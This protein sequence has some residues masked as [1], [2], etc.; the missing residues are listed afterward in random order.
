VSGHET[1]FAWF[2]GANGYF[3]FIGCKKISTFHS[4]CN[5]S[6]IQSKSFYIFSSIFCNIFFNFSLSNV[7]WIRWNITK[8]MKYCALLQI[9]H[10]TTWSRGFQ[11]LPPQGSCNSFVLWQ[12]AW[13]NYSKITS[14]ISSVHKIK[15]WKNNS[16]LDLWG[17]GR[18]F[19]HFITFFSLQR[20]VQEKYLI[21]VQAQ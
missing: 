17:E 12:L 16:I 3:S 5:L 9:F 21:I 14:S 19:N 2:L 18:T 7:A 11:V 6:S 1:T 13:G 8:W 15:F 10:G 4:I 20:I